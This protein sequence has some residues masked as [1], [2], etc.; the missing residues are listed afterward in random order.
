MTYCVIRDADFRIVK[1]SHN[2]RGILE[3]SRSHAVE[4]VDLYS[5]ARLF[6]VAWMDGATTLV[7]FA[8]ANVMRQW[9]ETRKCFKGA[10]FK[11]HA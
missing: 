6:G 4:R 11:H 10:E 5:S 3:Y 1:R 2:L 9:A 8:D 7:Q